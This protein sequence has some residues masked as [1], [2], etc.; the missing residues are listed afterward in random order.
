MD[1]IDLSEDRDHWSAF[2]NTVMNLRVPYNVGIFLS[3]R[4]TGVFSRRAQ[5]RGVATPV[6]IYILCVLCMW[7]KSYSVLI[8]V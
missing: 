4:A 7:L 2:V 3:S 6:I 1:W 8:T 5:F